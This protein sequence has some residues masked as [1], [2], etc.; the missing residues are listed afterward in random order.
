MKKITKYTLSGEEMKEA[1][2]AHLAL[3]GMPTAKVSSIMG[4]GHFPVT[5][6]E[7]VITVD[8]I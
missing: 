5:S 6:Y 2:M 7:I 3:K 1:V 8:V 4:K